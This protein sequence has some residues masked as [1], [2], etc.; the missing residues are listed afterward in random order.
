VGEAEIHTWG[1]GWKNLKFLFTRRLG[2][3]RTL[4]PWGGLDSNPDSDNG[5]LP[6]QQG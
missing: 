5:D 4:T 1:D 6:E 2:L 3:H